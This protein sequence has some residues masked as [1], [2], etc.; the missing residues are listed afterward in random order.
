MYQK[1]ANYKEEDL[2]ELEKFIDEECLYL[3]NCNITNEKIF[4]NFENN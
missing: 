4:D 1:N 2:L 3:D